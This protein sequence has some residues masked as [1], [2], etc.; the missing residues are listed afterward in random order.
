MLPRFEGEMD[1]MEY[2]I[3]HDENTENYMPLMIRD[4]AFSQNNVDNELDD[5][6]LRVE[7]NA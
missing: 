5:I 2:N 7:V 3:D 4:C 1:L 6:M